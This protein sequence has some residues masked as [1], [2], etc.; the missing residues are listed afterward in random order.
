[1][2]FPGEN[3]V[4]FALRRVVLPSA[5]YFFVGFKANRQKL[6][7]IHFSLFTHAHQRICPFPVI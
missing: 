3:A 7:I 4:I 2:R 1:M 6:F 5:I